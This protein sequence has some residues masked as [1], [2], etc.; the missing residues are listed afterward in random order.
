MVTESVM[1][2]FRQQVL[3]YTYSEPR[4]YRV[5]LKVKDSL[6]ME[7]VVVRDINL[8][9][10]DEE[11]NK[12]TYNS[13]KISSPGKSMTTLDISVSPIDV[14]KGGTVDINARIFNADNSPYYGKVYFEVM[15]GSGNFSPNPVSAQDSRASTVFTASDSGL[16]RIRIRATGTYYGDVMEEIVLNVK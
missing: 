14:S 8:N 3:P 7:N 15:E 16:V 6:G 11:R 4:I 1:M 2:M 5:R 13:I 9:L 12:S 10:T